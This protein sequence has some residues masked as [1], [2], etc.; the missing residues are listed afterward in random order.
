[1]PGGTKDVAELAP[2][3]DG[4]AV[5]AA[6][7]LEAVSGLEPTEIGQPLKSRGDQPGRDSRIG[8]CQP[9]LELYFED[10]PLP[11]DVQLPIIAPV[12]I[13]VRAA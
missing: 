1:L 3:A 7:L 6:A 4:Q 9:A 5:F 2:R 11:A 13:S 12:E 10:E 8:A